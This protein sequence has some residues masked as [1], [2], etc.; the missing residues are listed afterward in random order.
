MGMEFFCCFSSYSN[1]LDNWRQLKIAFKVT[2]KC[3]AL[4]ALKHY[5]S[6]WRI[7]T[8]NEYHLCAVLV[9][10][11]LKW[12]WMAVLCWLIVY[13]RLLQ[14][15][16]QV[17]NEKF[18]CIVH[19][20]WLWEESCGVDTSF[21]N[22]ITNFSLIFLFFFLFLGKSSWFVIRKLQDSVDFSTILSINR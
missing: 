21:S 4:S 16:E 18:C 11:M 7:E 9:F 10:L 2:L 15:D 22:L 17:G 19:F 5:K 13:Q 20:V 14:E 12:L 6:T 8:I 3:L 1:T